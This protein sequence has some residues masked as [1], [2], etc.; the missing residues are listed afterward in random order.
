MWYNA[1]SI[2]N[3]NHL[4]WR[5]KMTNRVITVNQ[6][7]VTLEKLRE[8]GYGDAQ[9]VLSE[10]DEWNGFRPL[11]QDQINEFNNDGSDDVGFLEEL[12]SSAI[13][14]TKKQVVLG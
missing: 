12:G 7:L 11:W 10:D 9:I 4:N 3:I 6:L 8:K 1:L 14:L 2:Q 5:K 13:D